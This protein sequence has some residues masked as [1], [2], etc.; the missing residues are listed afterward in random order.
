[1]PHD[2]EQKILRAKGWPPGSAAAR[3]VAVLKNHMS[4][5][6]EDPM[7]PHSPAFKSPAF[8]EVLAE[9]QAWVCVSPRWHAL[10]IPEIMNKPLEV[11]E[12]KRV[13][14]GL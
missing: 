14:Q 5:A 2:A 8:G 13:Q 11:L 4:R 3:H 1:M 9:A 12:A 10:C 7:R 6:I